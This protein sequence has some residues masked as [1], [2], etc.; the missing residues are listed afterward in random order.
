M[1]KF[2]AMVEALEE[3]EDLVEC[4]KC[5]DLFPKIDCVRQ[6]HGY[7]C[8]ICGKL[9]QTGTID[10]TEP[11]SVLTIYD[12]KFPDVL[13]YDPNTT[14]DYESEPQL[15]DVLGDLI[16]DEYEAIDGYEAADETVQH[17]SISEDEKDEILDTL[18]H[19]KEEE[20]EHID[21]LKELTGEGD[22]EYSDDDDDEEEAESDEAIESEE[23]EEE[24]E[25]SA[26]PAD[27]SLNESTSSAE[28]Y[29]AE[30]IETGDLIAA[31]HATSEAEAVD[32]LTPVFTERTGKLGSE[33]EDLYVSKADENDLL[34]I[35][36]DL[37]VESLEDEIEKALL[38]EAGI[39]GGDDKHLDN[40]FING[41]VVKV[42]NG[43]KATHKV[44]S[45]KEA[46]KLAIK[47]SKA[48]PSDPVYIYGAPLNAEY[49]NRNAAEKALLAAQNKETVIASYRK[50]KVT[51][52]DKT[53]EIVK[54]LK[55]AAKYEKAVSKTSAGKKAEEDQAN[56]FAAT[57]DES[58]SE[59]K[60][61]QDTEK[62]ES[63][64]ETETE[65]TSETE[66][67][68]EAEE[69]EEETTA[70][71]PAVKN[72]TFELID[73]IFTKG[74][75]IS[76]DGAAP[77]A[78]AKGT[79][80]AKAYNGAKKYSARFT[81]ENNMIY[82]CLEE[83]TED[84]ISSEAKNPKDIIKLLNALISKTYQKPIQKVAP[85]NIILAA[86][87]QDQ[88]VT[89]KKTPSLITLIESQFDAL[90][91]YFTEEDIF[92]P[93]AETEAKPEEIPTSDTA[94]EETSEPAAEPDS[95]LAAGLDSITTAFKSVA[96]TVSTK[97]GKRQANRIINKALS[98]AGI[99]TNSKQQNLI[100]KALLGESVE[101]ELESLIREDLK[102]TEDAVAE[103]ENTSNALKSAATGIKNMTS[104]MKEEYHKYANPA[105]ITA[106]DN[107]RVAVDKILEQLVRDLTVAG[108]DDLDYYDADCYMSGSNSC[109]L[110]MFLGTE[111]TFEEG[112]AEELQEH[113][114]NIVKEALTQIKLPPELVEIEGDA[115][116]PDLMIMDE[117][118]EA[119]GTTR[120]EITVEV[121]FARNLC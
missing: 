105:E 68:S 41:Y 67:T 46:E 42:L 22:S 71:A 96:G 59:T 95:K 20:E 62:T 52:L 89:L 108:Y 91:E 92:E 4:Q 37:F 114:A 27:S 56:A 24:K 94:A 29:I 93:A 101:A 57:T 53:A 23:T 60:T 70:T 9:S 72:E 11:S 78:L 16:R 75:S 49:N 30:D 121:T 110:T 45:Y 86:F 58:E 3:N 65:T 17:A 83:L 64:K 33:L 113:M 116:F 87:K 2:D 106:M 103:L 14:R 69:T 43:E 39:F 1:D 35:S 48:F 12:Q 120:G 112:E 79:T 76:I 19:I 13:D 117:D 47:T 98:A 115:L 66:A 21:E 7:L 38:T 32:I 54:A 82:L 85:K 77:K 31:C 18:E 84:S 111:D 102:S 55:N 44:G 74:Y 6:D 109:T 51:S 34:L 15:G 81:E 40:L 36:D 100:R 28:V 104:A 99:K 61:S 73:K 80:C 88:A 25:P 8:P 5:F 97:S 26:I 107:L 63:E 90:N 50:G 118:D 10:I 119:S